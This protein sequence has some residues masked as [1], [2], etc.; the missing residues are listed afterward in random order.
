VLD[1]EVELVVGDTQTRSQPA[2]DAANRLVGVEGVSGLLGALSSGNTVPVATSVSAVE[3]VPQ[4]SNASTAPTITTLDDN[5]FLFRT[6]PSDAQQGVV[7]GDLVQEEGIERVAIL[8]VNNDYGQGLAESFQESFEEAGGTVTSSAA[9]EPNKASYRGE[10]SNVSS[11]DPEA[12]LLIAYPDDGGLLILRQSLE[13]G[14]FERFIFTD[15]MKATQVATD[16]G[17]FIEGAFGT[18]PKAAESE[19]AQAF[20]EAYREAYGELPPLPFIDSAYDATMIL[21]L[22]A[23][24]AGSADGEAIRDHIRD[25]ANAPGEEVGPGE[26]A[27][28]KELLAAG[29]AINYEGAAGAHE[30]DEQ[31]DVGGSYEHWVITGGELETVEIVD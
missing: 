6:V 19:E 5:D 31:G 4:I 26:F 1:G 28:A 24:A 29:E 13:E 17:E 27:R 16:F 12:L 30:F 18:A 21:M 11:G 9:F 8:Y 2:V 25:V 7:L 23:Q 14:F 3:G 15:G 10:L 20:A 22:A